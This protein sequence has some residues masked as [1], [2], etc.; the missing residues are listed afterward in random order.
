MIPRSRGILVLCAVAAVAVHGLGLWQTAPR[1]EIEVAAGAGAAEAVQ[2][3]S[4]ADMAAGVAR[5]VSERTVTPNRRAETEVTPVDPGEAARPE[6]PDRT[7]TAAPEATAEPAPAEP[8]RRSRPSES[9][10]RAE[11]DETTPAPAPAATA[12]PRADRA[13]AAQPSERAS[14]AEAAET[15]DA[16]RPARTAEPPAAA[17][18][19]ASRPLS[20][21]R[22][23]EAP[24]AATPAG[25][26]TAAARPQGATRATGT[27]NAGKAPRAERA[28]PP[29]PQ[30]TAEAASAAQPRL[31]DSAS[32]PGPAPA[33]D[34]SDRAADAAA[35]TATVTAARGPTERA[36]TPDREV[37]EAETGPEAGLG[38]SRRP[39]A[40]PRKVEQAAAARQAPEPDREARTQGSTGGNA[41]R[42][43]RRGS[44]SGRESAT[45]T[46][47]GR[48]TQSRSRAQGNAAASNYPGKVMRHIARVPRPRASSRGAAVVRFSISERGGLS[49][50]RLTRS[51][52]SSRLDRAAMTVL[53]R[54]APF[55]RPP[56]GAKRSFTIRIEGR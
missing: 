2:G 39:Q 34:G 49:A 51:S 31:A 17:T 14:R 16:A 27:A 46:R 8:T 19:A 53:R 28:R 50:L 40:R 4:F 5:P 10:R 7:A 45:A 11:P 25:D 22:A 24:D 55:P 6:T 37:T 26:A 33:P 29:Q 20:R 36:D 15:A 13:R 9:P 44:A 52:G 18:A 42:N 12:P 3:S 23:P 1:T 21:A 54:A 35:E 56:R 47:Q 43:A 32:S 38:V 48:D 41:E 30:E